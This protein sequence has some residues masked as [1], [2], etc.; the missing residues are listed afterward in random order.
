MACGEGEEP[1]LESLARGLDDK[2]GE[3]RKAFGE[4]G[5]QRLVVMAALTLAD[6][7]SEALRRIA[8]LEEDVARLREASANADLAA[9]GW[10]L[11]VAQMLDDLAER[12]EQ[13]AR[14]LNG[15]EG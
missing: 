9:D 7:R 14:K 10:A 15:G 11:R 3:L 5:D 2:I 6:E 13:T 1:H 4:I 8:R 12:V